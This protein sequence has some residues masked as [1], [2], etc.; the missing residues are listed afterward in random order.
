[1]A[2]LQQFM[3]ND[4]LYPR[5]IN[6]VIRGFVWGGLVCLV[7]IIIGIPPLWMNP[8]AW[9]IFHLALT[10]NVCEG[11]GCI[12]PAI[13]SSSCFWACVALLISRMKLWET[14]S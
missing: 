6:D 14:N 13:L 7:Q 2:H 11:F 10:A 8:P 1:M 12:L 4:F 3:E 5:A 9:I